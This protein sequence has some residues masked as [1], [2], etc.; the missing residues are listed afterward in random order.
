M[1]TDTQALAYRR[2]AA[3]ILVRAALD[4]RGGNGH[5][6]QARRW[7]VSSP[8]AGD[9]LAWVAPD[10]AINVAAWV[11]DLPEVAQPALDS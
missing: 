2:L 8:W 3:A 1:T 5:A 7:L 6:A 11:G 10:L 4:A 9:L